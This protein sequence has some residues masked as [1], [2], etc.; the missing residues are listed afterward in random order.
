MPKNIDYK[1]ISTEEELKEFVKAHENEKWLAFDT[2][3]IGEKRDK[4][5]LC[6][7][8]VHSAL[9]VFLIDSM[10]IKDIKPFI[11][12]IT[13]SKIQKITHAGE[14]DYKV[15]YEL[16][17]II[18][19]NVADIQIAAGFVGYKY[20]ISLANV[21]QS[22][23]KKSLDKS[24]TVID[25]SKR[26][27]N[28]LYINYALE[29]VIYLK[30]VYDRLMVKIREQN[31]EEWVNSEFKILTDKETYQNN[32]ERE[33]MMLMLQTKFNS[34]EKI[35]VY[36]LFKWRSEVSEQTGKLREKVLP[37]K[38][39]PALAR[40]LKIGKKH[41]LSNRTIPDALIEQYWDQ[42]K[43]LIV[44]PPSEKEQEIIDASSTEIISDPIAESRQE[45]LLAFLKYECQLKGIDPAIVFPPSTMKMIKN[46]KNPGLT[47]LE[48]TWRYEFL[49]QEIV[50]M[51]KYKN[52]ISIT[53]E[54]DQIIIKWKKKN[55][56]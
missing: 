47:V 8:Q 46:K 16:Y 20:P 23:L 43:E 34:K 38:Y 1:W 5:L 48:T 32:P 12:L 33:A 55:K 52:D 25:W 4:T 19:K 7:I 21:L 45:L 44:D 27:L 35:V 2:E 51:I 49:G 40:Q 24:F 13:S 29:D 42:L 53:F 54:P 15:F 50:D 9:G 56:A 18:P 10:E 30:E 17:R 37:K 6:L 22:E 26:P 11:S 28:P 36:R 3:F 41:L 31:M 14:N 39:I